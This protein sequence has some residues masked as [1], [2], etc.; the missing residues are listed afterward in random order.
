M[1]DNI[2]EPVAEGLGEE[3]KKGKLIPV[4]ILVNVL[5]LAAIAVYLIAFGG[6]SGDEQA[7]QANQPDPVG[8]IV[9]LKGFTVN[10]N[11]RKGTK[12]LK[13][14]LNIELSNES[15]QDVVVERDAI[16][17]HNIIIY[18]SGLKSSEVQ[19]AENKLTIV[20]NLQKQL[21]EAI[22]VEDGIKQVYLTEF[23]WQ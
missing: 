13:V 21:N 1:A 12:Y 7:A 2:Q 8:M 16:M 20:E 3:P 4:L 14:G 15:I 10:L 18:L 5:V 9:P 22:G 11:D 23:R 19:G 17:R 6:E